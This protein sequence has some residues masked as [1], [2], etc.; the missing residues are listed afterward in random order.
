MEEETFEGMPLTLAVKAFMDGEEWGDEIKVNEDRTTATVATSMTVDD[1][2]YQLFIEVFEPDERIFVFFYSPYRVP[3][4]RLDVMARILL[5]V[6]YRLALGRLACFDPSE[7]AKPLQWKC[8]FDVEGSTLS[9][10]QVK[11]LISV[12]V[13]TWRTYGSLLA[14]AALSNRNLDD[15][16][17]EFQQKEEA[18]SAEWQSSCS[19]SRVLQ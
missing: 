18:C 16:W 14:M 15:L 4:G 10:I 11:N 6:N 12:G 17:A 9:P 7:E 2:P 19:V 3:I 13:G 8:G 5:R 1:Q